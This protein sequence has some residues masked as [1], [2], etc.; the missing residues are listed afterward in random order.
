MSA[1][2]TDMRLL[3]VDDNAANVALLEQLLQDAGYTNVLSTG[4]PRGVAELC[5]TWRPDLLLLDLHM[6]HLSGFQVLAAIADR[7]GEPVNLPVLV[8]TADAGPEARHRALSQGARDFVPK[9]LDHAEVL[10]RVRNLLHT[11]HLQQRL[12]DRNLILA[13]AVRER[14]EA[15]EHA[16]LEALT[17][18]AAAAEYRDDDTHLHTQRVGRTAALIAHALDLPEPA[19]ATIRDAAPLHDIG[20]IGLPDHILLKPGRLTPD[21]R[22]AMQRHVEIGVRILAPARSPV[23]R[24][25]A[26]IAR[27]HHEHWD[28]NGY[29]AGLH[30]E[31]IPL[32]ARITAVADVFDALT[33]QRPYKPAWPL[34]RALATIAQGA[35]RQFDPRA[36]HAF[37][38]LDHATLINDNAAPQHQPLAA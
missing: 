34:D 3:V 27:A 2:L 28:G 25:A 9:P 21:E 37:A 35:G 1:E 7:L 10:L 38:T 17:L 18:L 16:R 11:R 33:H 5:A 22:T 14:T 20:K 23:L 13:D 32:A 36:A 29:L 12:Q 19:V 24:A 6:P 30:G 15:L 26:D 31:D 8:L 4:D